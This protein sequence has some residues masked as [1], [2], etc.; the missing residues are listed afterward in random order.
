[1]RVSAGV[2]SDVGRV[3][4]RNEDAYLVQ[5]PVYAV[6]DGMGGH[7][8][9]DVAS[10]MSLEALEAA[11]IAGRGAPALTAAIRTANRAVLERGEADRELSGMGTTITAVLVQGDRAHLAHVGDS[12]AYLFRDGALRQL[13]EDHTMVQEMVRRGQLTPAQA[14]NH[15]QRSIITRALGAEG[16]LDVDELAVDLRPG[17]RLLLCSDGL[18][19][20]VSDAAIAGALTEAADPQAACDR[21]VEMANEAGGDDNITAVVIEALRADV[22]GAV[23]GDGA[24]RAGAVEGDGADRA[25]VDRAE[26]GPDGAHHL[27]PVVAAEASDDHR[28]PHRRRR[29]VVALV[30]LALLLAGAYAGVRAYVGRQ[31]YVGVSDGK[32]AVFNGVPVSFAGVHLS[33]VETPTDLPASQAEAL[34]LWHGLSDG[35]SA[36]SKDDAIAIVEQ[37]R[38]DLCSTSNVG[39]AG[40][41]VTPGPTPT[42]GPTLTA[43]GT[44]PAT[45]SPSR[46]GA[47]P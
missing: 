10:T 25:G 15:P 35:I 40:G 19:G 12:R 11:D 26:A 38:T 42:P 9:G 32:V 29:L 14:D 17:D 3:R 1:V 5:D 16:D 30:V 21:L 23:E 31:W 46:T 24:D 45:L 20:M 27:E 4:R 41:T 18:S 22:V 13:T 36:R 47:S 2:R 39:C 7:R 37:V 33:H 44:A 8:G 34:P 43:T 6:A 28:A